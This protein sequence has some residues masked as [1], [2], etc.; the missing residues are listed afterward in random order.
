MLLSDTVIRRLDAFQLAMQA[1][2]HGGAGGLRR[3]KALGSSVEFSDFR[4][5][6]PGDDLRRVD[7]NAY[8]RF[9]RLFLKLF[10]DEQETTLRIL[11]DASASMRYGEADKWLTAQRLAAALAYVSLSRYDRVVLAALSGGEV[12]QSETLGG[13]AAFPRVEAFLEGI[14]PDG[15]TQLDES[16][17]KVRITAGR[18]VCV[19]LSDLLSEN[20]WTLGAKQLQYRKQEV[21]VVQVLSPEELE[22]D[23]MG[24]LRLLDS[25]DGPACEVQISPEALKRYQETLAAFLDEQRQ[26]CHG[27]GMGYALVRSDMDLEKDALQALTAASILSVR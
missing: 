23:L 15:A 19:L 24:A 20:G 6:A 26:F 10:L 27:R 2:A 11:V 22:P 14:T 5:Y 3:A 18:G 16:L 13:R 9:D 12:R 4:D 21:S 1:H 8:A 7:W 25:E 17:S